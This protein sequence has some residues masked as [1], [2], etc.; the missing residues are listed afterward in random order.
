MVVSDRVL[1]CGR[2]TGH[3]RHKTTKSHHSLKRILFERSLE[4]TLQKVGIE[5]VKAVCGQIH[6]TVAVDVFSVKDCAG[7]W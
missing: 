6:V 4:K 3:F 2:P 1:R 5:N 7:L